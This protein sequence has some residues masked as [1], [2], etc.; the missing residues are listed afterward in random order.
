[1]SL[2][3][4]ITAASSVFPFYNSIWQDRAGY[5]MGIFRQIKFIQRSTQERGTRSNAGLGA[6]DTHCFLLSWGSDFVCHAVMSCYGL[7][8]MIT[9]DSSQPTDGLM[10]LWFWMQ[11]GYAM[12]MA[13]LGYT[14]I[15]GWGSACGSFQYSTLA[16][17][18]RWR[19]PMIHTDLSTTFAARKLVQLY[20]RP[21]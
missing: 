2:F 5:F 19:T 21:A 9:R 18:R 16:C 17:R 14:D 8:V 15:P 7:F 12:I 13:G 6:Q 4:D 10:S 11:F 1:M 20:G 3:R